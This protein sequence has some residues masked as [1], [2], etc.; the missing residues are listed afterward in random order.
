MLSS[1]APSDH[2]VTMDAN[3]TAA[4]HGG[5]E[6]LRASPRTTRNH[7]NIPALNAMNT[8]VI[9]RERGRNRRPDRM[10]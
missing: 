5:P 3:L 8:A 2:D 9:S 6:Q 10:S 4:S 1:T 7:D